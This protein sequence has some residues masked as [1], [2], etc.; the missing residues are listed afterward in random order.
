M[1]SKSEKKNFVDE[2]FQT[3]FFLEKPLTFFL[4]DEINFFPW[5]PI[6]FNVSISEK[7]C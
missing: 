2:I 7:K 4:N 3:F 5:K 1:S 6:S